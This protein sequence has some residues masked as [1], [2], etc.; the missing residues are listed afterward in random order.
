MGNF[1]DN[2]VEDNAAMFNTELH[3]SDKPA[4]QP[5]PEDHERMKKIQNWWAYSRTILSDPRSECMRDHDVYDG[6]SWSEE[7]REDIESRGQKA[8]NFNRVKPTCDWLIGSEKKNRIDYNVL[9]RTQE[10]SK[11]AEVKTQVLKYLSDVNHLPVERSQAFKDAVISGLGWLEAG[12]CNEPGE[13]PIFIDYED[14]R[15]LWYDPLSVRLDMKDCRFMIRR[16]RVDLDVACAMFPRFASELKHVAR[17]NQYDDRW[18]DYSDDLDTDLEA[19]IED[20]SGDETGEYSGRS[21]IE[22]V[23]CWYRTPE[24]VMVLRDGTE[25]LGTLNGV[26]YHEHEPSHKNLVEKGYA[27]TVNAIRMVMRCMIISG[28]TI[29]QDIESPYNHGRF[30]FV[31]IWGYRKKRDNTQYGVVRNLRDIQDDLN[32]RRSKALFILATNQII[33][34]EDAVDEEYIDDLAYEVSR[35]DGI[36]RKKSGRELEIRN[37]RS[38]AREHVE[39]MSQDAEYIESVGGVTD[40][41]MGRET[42]AVSGRAIEKRQEQGNIVNSELFDNLR[43]STQLLGEILLSLVEQFY[44]EEKIIRLTN[45][46]NQPE[47]VSLNQPD[48]VTGEVLNSI[49]AA[50]ADFVVD[51]AAFSASVRRATFETLM[52]MMTKMPPEI[53]LQLLDLVVALSD[54]PGKDD[55]VA[56]IRMVNGMT[57]PDADPN[58]PEAQAQAN[59]KRQQQEAQALFD[60]ALKQLELAE[61]QSIVNKNNM[62]AEAT[63]AGMD[64]DQ[65]RL[66][67]DKAKTLHDF[68]MDKAEAVHRYQTADRDFEQ[69]K[70]E[71]K[72][73][74]ATSV[75]PGSSTKTKDR[76]PATKQGVR[77]VKS[78]NKTKGV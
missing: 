52:E 59:A 57:D 61:K 19:N 73:N 17:T 12:K 33:M 32:K 68:R 35:P 31:P 1:A 16:K 47:F 25:R 30:P 18:D 39:M 38:L 77:G 46:K 58:D 74:P 55:L 70:E 9:P 41:Q 75:K 28:N 42:N 44:T 22:L 15:N 23:E 50:K 51:E 8:I 53:S 69:R 6:D 43:V 72:Q 20:M 63:R 78:D 26:R 49:T 56:R 71:A 29:L 2:A 21:R 40:E 10:D 24:E 14:W 4:P 60:E 5:D 48:P 76:I 67:L 64:Y 3:G 13:E 54:I 7:D 65:E 62:D 34:D 45:E 11:G 36:I 66:R 27:T 37:D